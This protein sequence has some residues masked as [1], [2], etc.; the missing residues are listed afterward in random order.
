[1]RFRTTLIADEA[2][3]GSPRR[4]GRGRIAALAFLCGVSHAMAGEPPYPP[5][6]PHAEA[7]RLVVEQRSD[8]ILALDGG[9]EARWF[10]TRER[11]W[12]TK[13]PISPGYIDSRWLIVVTYNIDGLQV[14]SWS[15]NTR[16]G[17]V[18]GSNE[19]L[20]IEGEPRTSSTSP[21]SP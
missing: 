19:T 6:W 3:E 2:G 5:N 13:R 10:D 18:A 9:N 8:E 11:T 17:E 7:I 12:T 15:V 16:N 21:P 14:A 1:M 20:T 4:F